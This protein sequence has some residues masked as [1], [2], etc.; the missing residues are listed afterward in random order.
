MHQEKCFFINN[1]FLSFKNKQYLGYHEAHF[2]SFCSVASKPTYHG[3]MMIP[4]NKYLGRTSEWEA[5]EV[6]DTI[7]SEKVS[8][9]G[10]SGPGVDPSTTKKLP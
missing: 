5:L 1:S 4:Q 7:S 9:G 8:W 2:S 10:E 6:R 3:L